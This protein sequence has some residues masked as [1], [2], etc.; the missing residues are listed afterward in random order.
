MGFYKYCD[1]SECEYDTPDEGRTRLDAP[2]TREILTN[3][4]RCW[5]CNELQILD[6][7]DDRSRAMEDLLDRIEALEQTQ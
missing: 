4:Y 5:K 3:N 6:D 1:R 7:D 2:T